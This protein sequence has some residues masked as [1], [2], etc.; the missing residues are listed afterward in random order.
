MV[1]FDHVKRDVSCLDEATTLLSTPRNYLLTAN[2]E[3]DLQGAYLYYD[4]ND[5]R[6]I[7]S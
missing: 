7:R 1:F 6:W 5:E 3:S 2:V 4:L